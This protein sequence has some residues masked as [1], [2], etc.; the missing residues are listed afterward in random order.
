MCSEWDLSIYSTQED[1][2]SHDYSMP[3]GKKVIG[4]SNAIYRMP[5][6]KQLKTY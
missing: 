5:V 6:A 2:I 3:L 1:S 4:E